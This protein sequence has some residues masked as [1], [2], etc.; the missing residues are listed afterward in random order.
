MGLFGP[1][2]KFAQMQTPEEQYFASGTYERTERATRAV[3]SDRNARY[4]NEQRQ[5]QERTATENRRKQV[6]RTGTI[7]RRGKALILE[8]GWQF[9]TDKLPKGDLRGM[10]FKGDKLGDLTVKDIH[11]LAE[12]H[13]PNC[14]C[15]LGR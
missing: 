4:R 12:N 2:K 10:T 1:S 5:E 7:R 3:T 9:A 6:T 14:R 11:D 13:G 8:G 15:G